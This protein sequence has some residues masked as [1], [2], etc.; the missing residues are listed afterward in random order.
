MRVLLTG[1]CGFVGSA[2]AR[3]IVEGGLPWTLFGFDNLSRPGSELN[4]T[5][6]R[7]LGVH[8]FH[9]DLRCQSDVD[10]LPPVD[11]IVDCAAKPSVLAGNDSQ[12]SSRQLMENNLLSSI[13]LLER[14]K[15]A[16]AGFILLSTSRV[17]AIESLAALPVEVRHNA[18]DII[19]RAPLP[20]GVSF[21]GISEDFSTAPPI[22][23]YGASKLASEALA[24]EYGATF[25]FPVWINRCGVLA[26]AGQFGRADQ[27]IFSY[28]IHSHMRR[29]PLRYIGFGG[30]GYQVRDCLHPRDIIPLLRLQ[31]E[32]ADDSSRPRL[33]NV[34]GGRSSAMSLRQLTEWCDARFGVHHIGNDPRER[35]FDL[36]WVILDCRKAARAWDWKPE[37]PT[38]AI[39]EEITR[40]ASENPNWLEISLSASEIG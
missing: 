39:L 31:I 23:L 4:R 13:N 26:G 28:W 25:D 40:H 27:G 38:E 12:T 9:G 34:S 15:A 5:L 37:M 2:L 10:A 17:Y 11:W 24:L 33:V 30:Q 19:V 18:F 32:A 22:S 8:V 14:C 7:R 6:L 20:A 1:V 3:A 21:D 16:K 29:A 35:R 36:P